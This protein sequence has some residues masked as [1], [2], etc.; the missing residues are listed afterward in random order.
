MFIHR[1]KTCLVAGFSVAILGLALALP[2]QAGSPS[3]AGRPNSVSIYANSGGS[4]GSFVRKARALKRTG[5]AVRFTGRCDSACTLL[6]ALPRSQTCIAPGAYF[7][8]HAP[9]SRSRRMAAL[10]HRY[11]V[12][13]YPGWVRSQ[14]AR[15]GGLTR[16]LITINYAQASKYMRRC[17]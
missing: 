14:I 15:H 13:K 1:L 9:V 11:M 2:S 16:K 3:Q 12:A 4:V 5:T 17:A 6:L 10:T 7:R 8:F